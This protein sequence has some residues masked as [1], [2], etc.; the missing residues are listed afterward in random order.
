MRANNPRRSEK[1]A[2]KGAEA[3]NGESLILNAF[4]VSAPAETDPHKGHRGELH[5]R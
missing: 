3:Y 5:R 2:P 1:A 4:A